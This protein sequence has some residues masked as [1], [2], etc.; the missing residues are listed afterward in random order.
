MSN[1]IVLIE[2]DVEIQGITNVPPR[3]KAR[4]SPDQNYEA[5]EFYA[6]PEDEK[7]SQESCCENMYLVVFFYKLIASKDLL[8]F[9]FRRRRDCKADSEGVCE[10][11]QIKILPGLLCKKK[12]AL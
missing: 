7:K 1:L 4:S 5:A 12:F 3:K 10:I 9:K 6:Q 11:Y 2:E 8:T